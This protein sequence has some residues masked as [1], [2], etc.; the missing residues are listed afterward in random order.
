MIDQRN[1][2][3]DADKL[4][5]IGFFAH[6]NIDEQILHFR[7]FPFALLLREMRGHVADDASDG[8]FSCVNSD[9]LGLGN[10]RIHAADFA[11]VN[12]SLLIDKVNR[13]ADFVSVAGEHD[14]RRTAFVQDG[15]GVAIGV[16]ESFVG[17]FFN[18][19][20]PDAL[21][22]V[23]VA[24]RARGVNKLFEELKRL[25]T[26]GGNLIESGRKPN[27]KHPVFAYTVKNLVRQHR[28]KSVTRG[29]KILL[30]LAGT[31][32]L[33]AI[34]IAFA[35]YWLGLALPAV[36]RGYHVHY[37]SY[38]R[39]DYSHFELRDVDYVKDGTRLHARQVT[40]L[41]P[42]LWWWRKEHHPETTYLNADD[43]TL[44]FETNKATSTKSSFANTVSKAHVKLNSLRDWVALAE[45]RNGAVEIHDLHVPIPTAIWSNGNFS[46]TMALPRVDEAANVVAQI[47]ANFPWTATAA[48]P[49]RNLRLEVVMTNEA[50]LGGIVTWHTNQATIGATFSRNGTLPE[51]A[52]VEVKGFRVGSKDLDLRGYD[53]VSGALNA[54]WAYGRFAVDLR[55]NATPLATST[56]LE[57]FVANITA[58][59]DTNAATLQTLTMSSPGMEAHLLAPLSVSFKGEMLNQSASFVVK[60]D[61]SKQQFLPVR[62]LVTGTASLQRKAGTYPQV[63]FAISGDHVTGFDVE[64]AAMKTQGQL[65]WPLLELQNLDVR[66][67]NGTT[68]NIT[69]GVDLEKRVVQHGTIQFSGKIAEDLLPVGYDYE[70]LSLRAEFSGPVNSL[71]HSGELNF[72]EVV[73]PYVKSF[74]ASAKWDGQGTDLKTFE[75][76]MR[77]SS[78]A[79]MRMSGSAALSGTANTH[80]IDAKLDRLAVVSGDQTFALKTS[81]RLNAELTRTNNHALWNAQ[82]SSLQLRSARGDLMFEASLN[83]TSAGRF[84]IY[85]HRLESRLANAFLIRPI[86]E[87]RI[88]QIAAA[89]VWSNGP[90]K[91]NLDLSG[92]YVPSLT[93]S[94]SIDLADFSARVEM[95]GDVRGTTI[96]NITISKKGQPVATAYGVIPLTIQP[97]RISSGFI[98]VL[99]AND[100]DPIHLRVTTQTKAAFWEAITKGLPIS[101]QNPSIDLSVDGTLAQ[102]RGTLHCEIPAGSIKLLT[103]SVRLALANFKA[104]IAIDRHQIN[105]QHFSVLLQGQ[106]LSAS[107]TLPLPSNLERDW[108]K[109]FDWRKASITVRAADVQIAPFADIERR[110]ISPQGTVWANVSVNHGQISG[111][112]VVT[113]AA[114]RPIAQFGAVR[115][116][117]A[118]LNFARNRLEIERCVG[119]L[120]GGP[121]AVSGWADLLHIDPQNEA[122]EIQPQPSRRQRPCRAAV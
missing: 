62:G 54:T 89:A 28:G 113:N 81:T 85:G 120:S 26:H 117:N 9:A 116:I 45:L 1:R 52:F 55:A 100:N 108:R 30:W 102:P 14:A 97:A 84:S 47:G 99:H 122:A 92:Q 105:L 7:G 112:L 20:E 74:R 90:A 48:V 67:I 91:W 76:E 35:P 80:H 42:V 104:D 82:V 41:T 16:R 57:P 79:L 21:A 12:E 115:D 31:I 118:R 98:N 61:L 11:N 78:T 73:V 36:L 44:S 37:G 46:A 109:V 43:W 40:G 6:A 13:H 71:K 34:A 22:A 33:L 96:T 4:F 51:Q 15:D 114:T 72:G 88:G 111:S 23:F 110:F 50:S 63:T 93:N 121:I 66:F 95:F 58:S 53:D 5:G 83:G 38:H 56:N 49:R 94:S 24:G 106:P 87:V 64:A 77:V 39:L 69:T 65:N 101:I 3:A 17:V 18:V 70:R 8:P 32:V 68:A 27:G 19:I 107:G 10:C 60:A 119:T 86:A 2:V 29:K 75:A 25:F 103:N 59:G